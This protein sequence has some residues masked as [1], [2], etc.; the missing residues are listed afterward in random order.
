MCIG[1]VIVIRFE[2]I[3]VNYQSRLINPFKFKLIAQMWLTWVAI[4]NSIKVI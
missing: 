2:I 3:A 4:E 1:V